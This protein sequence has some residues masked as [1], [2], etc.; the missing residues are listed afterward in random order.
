MTTIVTV[1]RTKNQKLAEEIMF[2]TMK[3]KTRLGQEVV[4]VNCLTKKN[5]KLMMDN[6]S[7][8]E[9]WEE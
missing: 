2:L 8:M 5:G 7:I 3:Q 4:N 1:M 6:E 9:I